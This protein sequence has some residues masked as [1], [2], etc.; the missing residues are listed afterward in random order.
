[1]KIADRLLFPW[2][3]WLKLKPDVFIAGFQ[4]CGTTSLYRYLAALDD[5]A[6]GRKKEWNV[7]SNEKYSYND[8]LSNFPF[9]F[10]AP[11]RRTLCASHQMSYVARG[12]RRLHR[13]FPAARVIFIMRNPV[14]RAISRYTHNQSKTGSVH[15]RKFPYSFEALCHLEM[16]MVRHMTDVCDTHELH[17]KTAYLNPY[18]LPLTRGLYYPF[19]KSFLD[20]GFTCLFC[21]LEDLIAHF[22]QEFT[23]ILEF[24]EVEPPARLPQPVPYNVTASKEAIDPDLRESLLNFYRPFNE[25][26]FALIGQSYGWD[27]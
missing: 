17:A 9:S 18:G 26:L 27:E 7:L 2:L 3:P 4:K 14:D 6:P 16:A 5:F 13:H 15:D 10:L 22:E 11:G 19:V 20:Y 23:R 25:Q 12:V 24:L 1:M 8:Y 21:S